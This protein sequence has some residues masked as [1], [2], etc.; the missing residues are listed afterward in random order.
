MQ[1]LSP[2]ILAEARGLSVVLSVSGVIVGLLLWLL[3]WWG[4]RF[5]V[6]L[7]ATVAAGILGLYSGPDLGMQRLVAGLLLAVAAGALALALVRLLA[8]ASGGVATWLVMRALV[9][10]W[11]D[12]QGQLIC[13]LTGGLVGLLLFRFW[14]MALTSLAGTLLAGYA[15]L[16]L[17]DRLGHLDAAAWAARHALLLNWACGAAAVLGLVVQFLLDRRRQRGRDGESDG[18]EGMGRL[19]RLL[20]WPWLPRKS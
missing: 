3:G 13:L 10:A 15:G 19:R 5:W 14:I 6:V 20:T 1:L 9:P 12:L 2:D 7:A 4:H 8:F 16:C 11:D 17:A 18:A